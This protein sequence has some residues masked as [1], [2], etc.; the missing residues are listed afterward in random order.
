[1]IVGYTW[2]W[3]TECDKEDRETATLPPA[4]QSA[5]NLS[6][7]VTNKAIEVTGQTSLGIFDGLSL[8]GFSY[9]TGAEVV[10]P[11]AYNVGLYGSMVPFPVSGGGKWTAARLV[12]DG[13]KRGLAAREIYAINA[14][15]GGGVLLHG[16]PESTAINASR[17]HGF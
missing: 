10:C 9:L 6:D 14:R 4:S 7:K 16:S 12:L 13:I 17:Y 11:P 15:F 1:M 8:G 5:K 2:G 3:N